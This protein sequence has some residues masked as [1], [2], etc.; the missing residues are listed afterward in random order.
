MRQMRWFERAIAG[1]LLPERIEREGHPRVPTY[2]EHTP[3]PGQ[4]E[5]GR[6]ASAAPAVVI[7]APRP[8]A[9][10]RPAADPRSI[11][12]ANAV[13]QLKKLAPAIEPPRARR[14]RVPTLDDGE[15]TDVELKVG[16]PVRGGSSPRPRLPGVIIDE[17]DESNEEVPTLVQRGDA[18]MQAFRAQARREQAARKGPAP[19]KP[20]VPSANIVD[21]ESDGRVT[22]VKKDEPP[23]AGV[24][25]D[26]DSE[27]PTAPR[28]LPTRDDSE[29]PTPIAPQPAKKVRL[30]IPPSPDIPP[31]P[32]PAATMAA[33]AGPPP[34]EP[35][36]RTTARPP[37]P[38]LPP[39]P[40]PLPPLVAPRELAV[41]AGPDPARTSHDD[42]QVID[43]SM[44]QPRAAGMSED[45]LI[46]EADRL[47][48]EAVRRT[49]EA[50]AA[51]LRAE[52]K[53]AS[54]KLAEQAARIASEAVQMIRSAGLPAAVARLEEARSLEQHLQSG[55][56]PGPDMGHPPSADLGAHAHSSNPPSYP[57]GSTPGPLSVPPQSGSLDGGG[58]R[59]PPN[60]PGYPVG[61]TLAPLSVPPVSYA[62]PASPPA[63]RA[64]APPPDP[65]PILDPDQFRANLQ[66][67][68]MG[69]PTT[70]V[71][72]LALVAL[73]VV[74]V[75]VALLSK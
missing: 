22:A 34:A 20:A 4:D 12:A 43:R 54:A 35:P 33:P 59:P 55:K 46:A 36:N 10:P 25:V 44:L 28:R 66:P 1:E 31:R 29:A 13:Q 68:I 24:I 18:K 73:V 11:R 9:P 74:G 5:D 14:P 6:S 70:A 62:P 27:L 41:V 38:P 64:P 37:P 45:S 30:A 19:S 2:T 67:T 17:D 58:P 53:A 65:V 50:R 3:R 75:L 26:P 72:V 69:L 49:E 15:A 47:A 56:I 23:S 71:A 61:S 32:F 63:L 21:D 40:P 16:N 51:H 52:R 57:V 8:L 42:V 60:P 39:A 48:I 7:A